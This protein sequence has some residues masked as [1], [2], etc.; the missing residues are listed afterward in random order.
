MT[1]AQIETMI[2]GWID[3]ELEASEDARASSP[4]VDDEQWEGQK[5]ILG[6][7]LEEVW[8]DLM[9]NRLAG[10]ESV[11]DGLLTG[12]GVVIEK[13][14]TTYKRLCR[15]L[16]KA[17]MKVL[18]A[19]MRRMDGEYEEERP[20]IRPNVRLNGVGA[21]AGSGPPYAAPSPTPVT[22]S[23]S[24]VS[25]AYLREFSVRQARTQ[26]MIRAGFA[27]FLEAIGGDRPIGNITKNDCRTYKESMTAA[28]L[29]PA[30]VNKHLHCLDH[31]LTWAHGQ[32]FL[33]EEWKNPVTGLRIAKSIVKAQKVKVVPFADAELS[34]VFSS[35]E[36]TKWKT[37]HPERYFGLLALLLTA[38]R[39]E[40]V[41]QLDVA[42]VMQETSSGISYFNF[43][44][45]D[46]GGNKTLKNAQSRRVVPLPGLLIELGFLEYVKSIRH[47]RVFPQ[48][49]HGGDG[50]GDG[51]GK[52]WARLVLQLKQG[53][54]GKVLHSLRHGGISKF[55]ELGVPDAHALALTGHG[56][57]GM[58][59]EVHF[60]AYVHTGTFSLKVLKMSIDKLGEAYRETLK[61]LLI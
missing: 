19:E 40:E 16:L 15:E 4:P 18:K 31:C 9:S 21:N 17:K 30:T 37:R 59:G 23:F 33:P 56:R 25:E 28:K 54:K 43:T 12:Q 10:A 35:S 52:A 53:G 3:A 5:D 34:V 36:F 48:L 2:A 39:R 11:A 41:Y 22:K 50:Y 29:T 57:E 47:K 8:S 60:S 13:D 49:K 51:P 24:M 44:S 7:Q 27:K 20:A 45:D 38:A 42:D 58:S 1:T 46:A 55:A 6:D 26:G 14:S 32:G 61:G